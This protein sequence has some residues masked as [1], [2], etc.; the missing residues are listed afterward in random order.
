M[1][2]SKNDFE[3]AGNELEISGENGLIV[4]VQF[5]ARLTEGWV[6][7]NGVDRYDVYEDE[8]EVKIDSVKNRDGKTIALSESTKNV[9]TEI[10]ETHFLNL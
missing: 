1:N 5:E 8:V 2:F 3:I 9:L 4:S 10:I 6:D 7:C